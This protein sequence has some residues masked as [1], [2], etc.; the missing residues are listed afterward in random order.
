M[1]MLVAHRT[2][3]A[4]ALVAKHRAE[5][6]VALR[7]A[8]SETD[9]AQRLKKVLRAYAAFLKSAWKEA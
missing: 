8:K 6:D 4:K 3:T 5:L 1:L 9:S 2:P 7:A